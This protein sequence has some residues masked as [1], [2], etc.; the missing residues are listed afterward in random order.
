[1]RFYNLKITPPSVGGLVNPPGTRVWTSNPDSY[2]P[3]ALDIWFDVTTT[4][5]HTPTGAYVVSIAGVPFHDLEGA[6]NFAGWSLTLV[7]GMTKRGLPLSTHQPA[8]TTIV[9]G[10]IFSN[11]GNWEG[12][13]MSINFV[14][15]PSAYSQDH[16]GNL[17][18]LWPKG[19]SLKPY[20]LLALQKA[21]PQYKVVVNL[22]VEL[23]ADQDEPLYAHTLSGFASQ[24]N[25]LT[26]NGKNH[27]PGVLIYIQNGQILCTDYNPNQVPIPLH[28]EDFIG[29]P[30]WVGGSQINIF[31]PLRGD[32]QA[33]KSITMPKDKV[34]N[35]PGIVSTQPNTSNAPFDF[36]KLF[37][38]SFQV[39]STRHMGHFRGDSGKDWMTVIH[40]VAVS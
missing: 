23:I 25:D 20:L 32:I 9:E 27:Y 39:I 34:T 2:D 35:A 31:V 16:P 14:V 29:Q 18:L 24:I 26:V 15:L 5:M 37:S 12:T 28:Y 17:N 7:A 10:T 4:A 33:G 21:Y 6:N 3:G 22:S 11:V 19:K 13:E 38:G 30:T 1:M 36:K 8:P 40:A